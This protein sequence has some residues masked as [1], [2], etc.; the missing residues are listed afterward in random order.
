MIKLTNINKYFNYRKSNEI[1][2][3][4]NISIT[5]PEKGLVALFGTSG[6]GK[7]TLLNVI[8]GLDKIQDGEIEFEGKILKKYNAKEWDE[9]R[10]K[11]IG[12]IFQNYNLISS[13]SVY[14]NIRVSLNMAGLYDKEEIDE[15]IVYVLKAVGMDK[16][17]NR[18]V[19]ALSGG[20]QQRVAI[21]RALAKNPKVIIADEPTGNLD[22]NNTLEVMKI[23]KKISKDRLVVLVSHEKELVDFFADHIIHLEDGKIVDEYD[24]R[25]EGT[26]NRMDERNIYLRDLEKKEDKLNNLKIN[27]YTDTNEEMGLKLDIVYKNGTYY[28][29]PSTNQKLNIVDNSSEIKFIDAH[30]EHALKENILEHSYNIGDIKPIESI[31]NRK[32]FIRLGDCI[33][34]GFKKLSV[35]KWHTKLFLVGFF[36]MAFIFCF[37]IAKIGNTLKVN[38]SEIYYGTKDLIVLKY[39]EDHP[40]D[41]K[42]IDKILNVSSVKALSL[43]PETAYIGGQFTNFYQGRYFG[44]SNTR[45]FIAPD[46]MFDN[47]DVAPGTVIIDEWVA[48]SILK[49]SSISSMGLSNI[50]DM[51]DGIIKFTLFSEKRLIIA[52]IVNDNGNYIILDEDDYTDYLNSYFEFSGAD[53]IDYTV[54]NGRDISNDNEVLVNSKFYSSKDFPSSIT[55][56]DYTINTLKKYDIVGTFESDSNIQY[57]FSE[58]EANKRMAARFLIN[59]ENEVYFFT[60]N[61]QE[62]I[63][64]INELGM[65]NV[66]DAYKLQIETYRKG[67]IIDN[68]TTITVFGIFL[69]IL[70]VYL[71]FMM[72]SSLISRVKEVGIYRS[73]GATKKDII[74]IF[75]GEITAYTTI[76]SLIGYLL[77]AYFI[78]SVNN[79]LNGITEVFYLPIYL[80]VLGALSMYIVNYVFGLIPVFLL[81]RKTPAEI[82]SKYDI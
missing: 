40:Y 51:I 36:V 5:F 75:I 47:I 45:C 64:A 72:R 8:G 23:I 48:D 73:I 67:K 32:S 71:I 15:R 54:K 24:N 63:K 66:Y 6:S 79:A 68:L 44:N 34:D 33:K 38:P 4:N 9:I 77:C 62:A 52:D 59:E 82:M 28:I 81:V 19:M 78:Y 42:D 20:Q 17:K 49:N 76:G 30:F 55:F 61:K 56:G 41:E 69:M 70:L 50:E 22:S 21:A 2:V 14:D 10:N 46:S 57:I 27:Y 35:M 39:D 74:K 3:A 1:H 65:D 12:Y 80:L 26:L 16:Y 13:L 18:N 29:K 58:T 25:F 11:N 43:L 31:R 37:N 7:T 53:R 60:K